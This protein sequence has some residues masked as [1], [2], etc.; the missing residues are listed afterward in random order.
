MDKTKYSVKNAKM[1]IDQRLAAVMGTIIATHIFL[2]S[3]IGFFPYPELFVYPYLTNIGLMPYRQILDQHFPGLMFFPINLN[4]LGMTTV[5]SAHLVQYLLIIATHISLAVFIWLLTK[6]R[7]SVILAGL[8]YVAWQGYFDGHTLWIDSF[9]PPF[10]LTAAALLLSGQKHGRENRYFLS[11][12]ILGLA[13]LSKQVVLPLTGMLT[14]YL[15]AKDRNFRGIWHFLAGFSIPVSCLVLYMS[16]T[17]NLKD[18]FYWT[19]TFN[20]TVFNEMGRKFAT[21]PELFKMSLLFAPAVAAFVLL[22][23]RMK[24]TRRIMI[25]G[26]FLLGSLVFAYARFDYV[27]LQPSIPFAIALVLCGITALPMKLRKVTVLVFVLG[28]VIVGGRFYIRQW[29]APTLFFAESDQAVFD[30]VTKRVQKG[31]PVFA[32]ATYPHIYSA[33][34]TRPAGNVFVFQFPWFMKVAEIQVLK[35]LIADRPRVIVRDLTAEADNMNLV[36]YM[37]L[38]NAYINRYYLVD[39]KIGTTDIM[40][41]R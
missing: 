11:G 17:L 30:A 31:D 38:I 4:T 9:I 10:F 23:R 40:I 5:S 21:T 25:L 8:I 6:S 1:T 14:I 34:Q 22:L 36:Y 7:K 18:F 16:L 37:P 35:S 32:F 2:L 15:L 39:E 41:P 29:G 20:M 12:F 28:S 3:R 24:D 33:T 19:V 26:I 27:H 13:L